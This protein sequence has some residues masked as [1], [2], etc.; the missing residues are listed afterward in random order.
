M[1]GLVLQ[2]YFWDGKEFQTLSDT[3]VSLIDNIEQAK[4]KIIQKL[5]LKDIT[6]FACDTDT[7]NDNAIAILPASS[8]RFKDAISENNVDHLSSSIP[9][10]VAD[11]IEFD[12]RT[13]L[14]EV[15]GLN[16][17]IVLYQTSLLL[18]RP[19]RRKESNPSQIDMIPVNVL[20]YIPSISQGDYGIGEI[21]HLKRAV[22]E[23]LGGAVIIPEYEFPRLILSPVIPFAMC[24]SLSATSK[25]LIRA[26]S[27]VEGI[28]RN[29]PFRNLKCTYSLRPNGILFR[30]KIDEDFTQLECMTNGDI[31][32]T[33]ENWKSPITNQLQH[34]LINYA[35]KVLATFVNAIQHWS[36]EKP[37]DL[38]QF[39]SRY[40]RE[41]VFEYSVFTAVS[42]IRSLI[43]DESLV[44]SFV[45]PLVKTPELQEDNIE[46]DQNMLNCGYDDDNENITHQLSKR[47]VTLN[48]KPKNVR[49]PDQ[50]SKV[51]CRLSRS[52]TNGI[53][54]AI[55]G[56]DTHPLLPMIAASY[57][58]QSIHRTLPKELGEPRSTLRLMHVDPELYFSL[59][60]CGYSRKTWTCTEHSTGCTRYRQAIPINPSNTNDQLRYNKCLET[61][62][63]MFYRGVWYAAIQDEE[64]NGD[65]IRNLRRSRPKDKSKELEFYN[66]VI[67]KE[68]TET[69][70]RNIGYDSE[71]FRYI[72]ACVRFRK[73]SKLP[74]RALAIMA[75]LYRRNEIKFQGRD[76]SE[77]I[78]QLK[79]FGV[80][81]TNQTYVMKANKTLGSGNHGEI[82]FGPLHDYLFK[83]LQAKTATRQGVFRDLDQRFASC[84]AILSSC[85]DQDYMQ[86]GAP[87]AERYVRRLFPRIEGDNR[88]IAII[89]DEVCDMLSVQNHV[90]IVI[91]HHSS[92]E[93]DIQVS[94]VRN[95]FSLTRSSILLIRSLNG[96]L[97]EP[98]SLDGNTIFTKDSHVSLQLVN[99]YG[100]I[101]P[102]EYQRDT[103]LKELEKNIGRNCDGQYIS[104]SNMIAL[105]F[106][107]IVV[108]FICGKPFEH[109][110][111]L[112]EEPPKQR[113]D[114]LIRCLDTL[115]IECYK[116]TVFLMDGSSAFA[117]VLADTRLI[118][119]IIPISAT[120]SCLKSLKGIQNTSLNTPFTGL[121]GNMPSGETAIALT[122]RGEVK[123]Q[124]IQLLQA[125]Q[126][127]VKTK[128][129]EWAALQG[130]SSAER[131]R[132]LQTQFIIDPVQSV[133]KDLLI[134]AS[135]MLV[136]L[137][138]YCESYPNPKE[139]KF[140]IDAPTILKQETPEK[141]PDMIFNS[142]SA[143]LEWIARQE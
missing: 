48:Y 18:L 49:T 120:H 143:F 70:Y 93:Q 139:W 112:K 119:L 141:K 38:T 42:D 108:P 17:C 84:H 16:I 14:G 110:K 33:I 35:T 36:D 24:R 116:P 94:F 12:R 22:V 135:V 68:V 9:I 55:V 73:N 105:N 127:K 63:M 28:Q 121:K 77:M 82:P 6:L 13:L 136:I 123:Q 102:A 75:P 65:T 95:V 86:G 60:N 62:P 138:S 44:E 69:K 97:Y 125:I 37:I 52:L 53:V 34:E 126:Q 19:T 96:G 133:A 27:S 118:S 80:S 40:L 103:R 3:D 81:K 20:S 128:E 71:R 124:F 76:T 115:R 131:R 137:A 89:N 72:P 11:I 79:G 25:C 21:L 64:E 8:L 4:Q 106:L 7:P 134:P 78:K 109:L 26:H 45:E 98:I 51:V 61:G 129:N 117:I 10:S 114:Q 39:H 5:G 88:S 142:P 74:L 83:I 122:K 132:Q 111:M 104:G 99:L 43:D 15:R 41:T 30:V 1:Q 31:K 59:K 101:C 130:L 2:C 91:F 58:R 66:W 90:N 23:F 47:V 85:N 67:L 107:G 50:R 100:A 140:H 56:H 54:C 29:W 57:L 113:A 32:I 46:D 92:F 87:A